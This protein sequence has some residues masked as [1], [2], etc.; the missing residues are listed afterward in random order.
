[1]VVPVLRDWGIER[2]DGL[3]IKAQEIQEKLLAFP[4]QLA[5]QAEIF[6]RR[7]GLATP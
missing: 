7:V 2:L 1:V 6:E 5:R 3:S 4:A